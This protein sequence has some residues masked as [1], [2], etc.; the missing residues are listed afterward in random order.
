MLAMVAVVIVMVL[1]MGFALSQETAMNVSRNIQLHANARFIAESGL[2][3]A[4]N[5]ISN[6]TSWRS[7]Y[8]PGVWVNQVP[9]GGGTLTIRGDDG[10]YS[11]ATQSVSGD[12][13]FS[14]NSTDSLTLTATGTYNGVS[15]TAHITTTVSISNDAGVLMVVPNASS[16]T[17]SETARQTLLQSWGFTVTPIT[18][19]ASQ[20]TF[21]TAVTT[22]VAAQTYA[23]IY[24][25]SGCSASDILTK[26]N[27]YNTGVIC[28]Q[29]QLADDMKL[30]SA[31]ATGITASSATVTSITLYPTS[32][33]T[34]ASTTLTTSGQPMWS[35]AGTV[36]TGATTLATAQGLSTPAMLAIETSASLTS[37]TA[38]GRR[39]F[40]PWGGSSFDIASLNAAGQTLLRRAL[41]W[42]SQSPATGTLTTL[43]LGYRSRF[44]SKSR[45]ASGMQFATRVALAQG[46]TL[47]SISAYSKGNKKVRMAIYADSAGAPGALLA[48]TNSG[49]GST[50]GKW[51][52][53]A[54][55]STTLAAGNYWL[56]MSL[57]TSSMYYYYST[58][59]G[60]SRTNANAAVTSGFS[61]PWGTSTSSESRR[62]SIYASVTVP[63]GTPINNAGLDTITSFTPIWMDQP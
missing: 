13:S 17:T 16:L 58:S 34:A 51:V 39:L 36:A 50:A 63:P 1:T 8:T 61:S 25:T 49:T 43:T 7:T 19:S 11:S 26:L 48:Q 28:E 23:V 31:G 5:R 6:D 47:N 57:E 59:G 40:L 15:H 46:G 14:N 32:N 12:G 55:P 4:L 60:T 38:A 21:D 35:Y 33:L 62:I 37:G 53:V 29:G 52:T 10:T 22:L 3:I 54:A 27:G 9:Y 41:E 30:V 2:R 20:A 42:G 45:N 44:S 56:A 24:V 18:A